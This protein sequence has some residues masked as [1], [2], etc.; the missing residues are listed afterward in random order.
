MI[1]KIERGASG[2]RFPGIERLA[3]ALEV[4]PAKLFTTQTAEGATR[5]GLYGEILLR[6]AN[7]SAAELQMVLR[8]LDA[9][10]EDK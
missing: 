6:L 5:R 10:S 2:A 7:Y 3:K 8:L 4:D 9:M 1:A